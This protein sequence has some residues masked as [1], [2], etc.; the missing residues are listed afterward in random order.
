MKEL[1]IIGQGPAGISAALYAVRGGA[2]V[3]VVA[4]DGG[5]LAKAD[6]IQ[7]Y[8]GFADGVSAKELVANGIAQAKNLG[9][10]F[11]EA[12]VCGVEFGTDGFEVK[13]LLR[14]L[15]R[16]LFPRE[17]DRRHRKRR[18]RGERVRGVEK[19]H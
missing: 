4:K 9:V 12:E 13:K 15:R 1:V 14:N 10:K 8:Y 17:K 18:L 6:K 11:I 16:V 7:N 5:A 3:T 2:S 19:H